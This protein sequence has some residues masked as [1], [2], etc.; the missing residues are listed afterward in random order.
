MYVHIEEYP[1]RQELTPG[2]ELQHKDLTLEGGA[3]YHQQNIDVQNYPNIP[4]ASVVYKEFIE[5]GR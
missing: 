3:H 5:S 4:A 1:R 2:E